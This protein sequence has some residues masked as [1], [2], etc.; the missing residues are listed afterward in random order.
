MSAHVKTK[1]SAFKRKLT[2]TAMPTITL[3]SSIF[4]LVCVRMDTPDPSVKRISM[5]ARKIPNH[6]S[7][8][9]VAL[10]CHHLQTSP[11]TRVVH[12]PVDTLGMAQNAQFII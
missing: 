2:M 5:H 7:Q 6:V 11:A 3:K 4:F 10:I 1:E 12:A 8:E 9:S